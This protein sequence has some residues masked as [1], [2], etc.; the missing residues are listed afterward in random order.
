MQEFSGDPRILAGHRAYPLED[1]H[2][3]K[4]DV[5]EVANRGGHYVQA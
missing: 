5:P 2:G 1:L 3:T 4:G